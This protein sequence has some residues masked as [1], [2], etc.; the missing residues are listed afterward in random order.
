MMGFIHM[1]LNEST[2]NIFDRVLDKVP[3]LK[4]HIN[5]A[6]QFDKTYRHAQPELTRSLKFAEWSFTFG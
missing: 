6:K 5:T 4:L 2:N 1:K 3:C